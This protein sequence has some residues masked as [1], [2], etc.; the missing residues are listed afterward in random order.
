MRITK[1]TRRKID[2]SLGSN[3]VARSRAPLAAFALAL[4]LLPGLCEA[5]E[6]DPA[7]QREMAA[8][9]DLIARLISR[10][11]AEDSYRITFSQEAYWAL[12]DTAISSEGVLLLERPAMLSV[13]YTDGSTVISDGDTLW[14]YMSQTNQ[15]FSAGIGEDDTVIDPPRVL[16]QYVPDPSDPYGGSLEPS[17]GGEATLRLVPAQGAAEPSRLE[18]TVDT[19]RDLVT[20]MV[21]RTRSGDRTRYVISETRFGVDTAPGDFVFTR[22]AGAE[23]IGR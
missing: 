8:A 15:Y 4:L 12:A 9:T 18:V 7:L 21:A 22:P 13:R 10:Y 17:S 20:G 23:R 2:G 11:E 3:V 1:K 14:V 16:R 19:A 6:A 5:Q